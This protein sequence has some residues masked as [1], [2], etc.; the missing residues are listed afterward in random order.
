MVV[1]WEFIGFKHLPYAAYAGA[2]ICT[3]IAGHV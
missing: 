3:Y 1:L 2:G